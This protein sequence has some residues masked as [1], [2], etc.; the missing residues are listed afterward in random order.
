[1]KLPSNIIVT[2]FIILIVQLTVLSV[3]QITANPRY[4][5]PGYNGNNLA[6]RLV[7]K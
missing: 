3:M 4:K 5:G 6:G 7:F 1:M 2:T